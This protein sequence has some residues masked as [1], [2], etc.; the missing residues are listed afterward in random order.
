MKYIIYIF[1]ILSFSIFSQ[2]NI[3]TSPIKKTTLQVDKL[4]S[5]DNFET[6]YFINHNVFYK[7]TTEKTINFS[8]IQLGT[9]KTVS[10]FNPLKINIF[11]KDFNTIIILDNRLAEIFKIDFNTKLP[12]RNISFVSTGYDN[13]LW[14]FNQDSQQLEL[15]DYKLNN[16]RIKTLP[17]QDQ[18]ID[19]TSNYNYCYLL[20]EKE[21][22]IYNYFGSLILKIK[23]DGYSSISE[24]NKNIILKKDNSLIYLKKD[25]KN[26]IPIKL[27]NLLINQFFVTNETLYIYDTEILHQFQLKTN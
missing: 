7:K 14:L 21:L 23:N 12:Y 3:E 1:L 9:I 25:T 24:N 26:K 27:P 22:L 17:I 10:V 19:M 6:S 2:E 18:V 15:Y 13:T 4:I 16:T 20:T 5:I 8:N 11:Y